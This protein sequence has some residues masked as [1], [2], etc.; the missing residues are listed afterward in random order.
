MTRSSMNVEEREFE[1]AW[2]LIDRG[3]D[4]LVKTYLPHLHDDLR[5]EARCGAWTFYLRYD[6][7]KGAGL[8]TWLFWGARAAIQRWM[9]DREAL[10]AIPRSQQEKK[11]HGFFRYVPLNT[12]IDASDETGYDESETMAILDCLP[13]QL[14]MIAKLFAAG[15]VVADIA[16]MTGI[17]AQQISKLKVS[18]RRHLYYLASSG[19]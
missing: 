2:A 7:A 15:Y 6:R 11:T 14:S 5:Q 17:R 1:R 12:C 16:R 19:S 4:R 8:H 13:R 3:V 9:R 18:L 10:I